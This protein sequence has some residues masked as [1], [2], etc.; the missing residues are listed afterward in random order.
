M[1]WLAIATAWL[2]LCFAPAACG[3]SSRINPTAC[4]QAAARPVAMVELPG[5]PFQAIPTTDGCYVFV[6]LVGPVE[7]GDPRR[8][9]QPGAP[10]GGVAVVRRAGG[11]PSLIR[12]LPLEGSPYGMALTHD[13]HLLIVASDDRVAFID[14][15][16]LIAGSADAIAGYLHDAP[17][18]GRVYANVTPD[19]R[20]LFLSDESTR[21]ISVVN[22]AKARASG[23]D[24]SV[25]IGQIPVGR[26]PIALTFS[27]D[28]Q[29]LYTTSQVAPAA[30]GWPSEC[31]APGSDVA[32]Q[33][34]DYAKGAI[35]VVDVARA[36]SDPANAVVGVVSAGCNPVR[37]ITSPRG[38]IA[39]VTARTDNALLAFDTSK[40]LTDSANAL[41]ARVQVG[42]AP[43]GVAVL[44]DGARLAVT[45]SNR[46][47]NSSTTQSLTIIDAHKIGSG[48]A[49][50][51]GTVPV[52]VFPRELR[53][54]DDQRTLLLTNF[55]SK[56]LAV[57][58]VARLPLEPPEPMKR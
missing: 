6:S 17:T 7:P 29:F 55:G 1:R 20:W 8:P 57:I 32:R 13:G 3:P 23:F 28:H 56:T 49:A 53:V 30:Y 27:S 15:A 37:L 10:M 12:V 34:S 50:I 52:G 22:L 43:V 11:E 21:T 38:D 33:P 51:L 2:S 18:A 44:N 40:L 25:V 26:A 4:V 36:T 31:H 24:N 46:F 47:G 9:P 16:R 42:D 48:A 14:P 35:L 5:S 41:I 19:D 45:N 54:T 58:D 39:Y